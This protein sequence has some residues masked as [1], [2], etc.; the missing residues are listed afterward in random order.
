MRP[1]L[2]HAA[3][4][5]SL[6]EYAMITALVSVVCITGLNLLGNNTNNVLANL[7]AGVGGGTVLG[8]GGGGGG[9]SPVP[10][11]VVPPV[12]NIPLDDLLASNPATP[13]ETTGADG[14]LPSGGSATTGGD[15]GSNGSTISTG[16]GTGGSSTDD[17]SASEPTIIGDTSTTEAYPTL[18]VSLPS[19]GGSSGTG[20]PSPYTTEPDPLPLILPS[21][22]PIGGGCACMSGASNLM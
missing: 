11:A 1:P 18:A 22:T 9:G 4:G 17:T 8:G 16:G 21:T 13:T 6:V 20:T 14:D 10:M 3:Y 19:D 15:T 12:S 5:Q 7:S 2:L